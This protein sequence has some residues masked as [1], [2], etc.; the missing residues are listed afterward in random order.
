MM[1]VDSLVFQLDLQFLVDF[2]IVEYL[3]DLPQVQPDGFDS[4]S[5]ETALTVAS[6]NGCTNVCSA[7]VARGARIT[8]TNQKVI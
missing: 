4:L 3:L 7:L 2:Q 8:A 6:M 5:G 1:A